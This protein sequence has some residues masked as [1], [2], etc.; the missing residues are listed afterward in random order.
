[1]SHPLDIPAFLLRKDTAEA[2]ARRAR[3]TARE[4]A[5]HR[6]KNPPKRA[7]KKVMGLGPIFGASVKRT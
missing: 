3:I 5:Q 7:S 2:K 1:V 4:R 6:I